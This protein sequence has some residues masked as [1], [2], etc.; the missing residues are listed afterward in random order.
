MKKARGIERDRN[1]E[2]LCS[3]VNY[4]FN[5]DC[6]PGGYRTK[7]EYY[8]VYIVICSCNDQYFWRLCNFCI[9]YSEYGYHGA[10]YGVFWWSIYAYFNF[11][12]YHENVSD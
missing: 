4:F 5:N 9:R 3:F 7:A 12:Q 2:Y 8:T 6:C 10:E 11:V 1:I